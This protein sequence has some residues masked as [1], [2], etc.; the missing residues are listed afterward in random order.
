MDTHGNA[1]PFIRVHDINCAVLVVNASCTSVVAIVLTT[2]NVLHES[3]C[4]AF[5]YTSCYFTATKEK[6]EKRAFLMIK[7]ACGYFESAF[8]GVKRSCASAKMEMKSDGQGGMLE[9]YS[10]CRQKKR[11]E[12]IV[13]GYLQ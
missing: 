8:H 13:R 10:L 11:V 7:L 2:N 12:M 6:G 1:K 4:A 9:Y 3:T 5:L